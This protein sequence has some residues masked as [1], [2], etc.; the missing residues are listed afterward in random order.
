[1]KEEA[2]RMNKIDV[3]TALTEKKK[4]TVNQATEIVNLMFD[5]FTNELKNGGRIEIRGFGSFSVR[6]YKTY[7][8]RNDYSAEVSILIR[9]NPPLNSGGSRHPLIGAKR[10]WV[11]SPFS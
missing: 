6:E 7:K 1:M 4:L 11:F 2:N 8:G 9:R 3:V 5:G 10:R